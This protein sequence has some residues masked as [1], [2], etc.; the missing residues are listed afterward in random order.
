[1]T[2][3]RISTIVALLACYCLPGS[4]TADGLPT[5]GA[6]STTPAAKWESAFVTGNGRM[7][8][9]IFGGPGSETVVANHC[10]LFLPLG[11]REIVPNL[12]ADVPELRRII[13][14]K[15]YGEAM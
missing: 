6:H 8:A 2:N 9:L 14:N 11:N 10:R 1:M 4:A 7:G 3:T 13:R 12:A 15:G 5:H